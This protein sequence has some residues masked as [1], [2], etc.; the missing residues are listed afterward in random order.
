MLT[1][2]VWSPALLGYDFGPGHPMTPVRLDLTFRLAA[3]LGVLDADGVTLVGA[4]PASDEVLATAHDPAYVAAVQRASATGRPDP[5][6]G[7]G[8]ADDPCFPGMHEA[9]ARIVTGS[10]EAADALWSGEALHAVNI[11]GGMHHAMRTNAAGFC[12]YNDAVAAI[13]R[14]LDAGAQRVAYV[15]LDAHHG[16]GVEAA[17]WDDPRVLTVSVHE[18]GLTLF[19][20]TG[21]PTDVGGPHARGTVVNVAVPAGTSDTRWLRAVDAVA[22]TVAR[23]F[24]PEVLVTQHGCDAHGQDPL[25]HLDVSVDAQRAAMERVHALAHDV[26]AGRWL[27]LGGGGYAVTQVVPR[28][29]TH[30]LAIAAHVPIDVGTPVPEGFAEHVRLITSGGETPATMGDGE[31]L[32]APRGWGEGYDPHDDVDRVILA[33]RRAVFEWHD[34]DPLY[35]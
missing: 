30:L 1:R 34:L 33:A 26:C 27:A 16:D 15:D 7:L 11:A 24:A 2:V 18:S 32:R 6:H 31:P 9:A 25:T 4:E 8:T 5:S 35:D 13:R 17:F 21:H 29:W 12:I 28:V 19:P 10:V 20:G 23:A 3:E 22:L 14:L